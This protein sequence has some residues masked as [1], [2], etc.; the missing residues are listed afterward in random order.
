MPPPPVHMGWF[1][2]QA[3]TT[4]AS[5]AQ[6]PTKHHTVNP[7]PIQQ[8]THTQP[9]QPAKQTYTIHNPLIIENKSFQITLVGGRGN[10]LCITEK[11]FKKPVGKLWVGNNNLIWL[12]DVIDQAVKSQ[13][14]G[15]FFKHRRDGYKA[16]HVIRRSNKNGTFLETSE[17][18]SGS[19]QGVIRIPEGVARQGWI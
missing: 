4:P 7:P 9:L 11:K 17:F 3:T 6:P 2:H 8:L 16:I 1:N 12:G 19:R 15:E 14:L 18:H 13:S 5:L 10:L